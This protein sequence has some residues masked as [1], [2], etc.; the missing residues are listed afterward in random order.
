M[1]LK[2]INHGLIGLHYRDTKALWVRSYLCRH[3]ATTKTSEKANFTVTQAI[4]WTKHHSFWH[5]F[6]DE[7]RVPFCRGA[8]PFW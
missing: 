5:V 7:Y 2:R 6:V 1:R 4:R 3:D 8:D